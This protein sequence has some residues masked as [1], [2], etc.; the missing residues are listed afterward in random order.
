MARG[1]STVRSMRIIT[2]WKIGVGASLLSLSLSC[3]QT[4]MADELLPSIATERAG[5]EAS[6]VPFP[7]TPAK[8]GAWPARPLLDG[9]WEELTPEQAAGVVQRLRQYW[10][11]LRRGLS[12]DDW[13]L[14]QDA[15]RFRQL[16]LPFYMNVVLVEGEIRK[17]GQE[18]GLLTFLLHDRG[19]TLLTDSGGRGVIL[20]LNHWNPPQLDAPEYAAIYTKLFIGA[21]GGAKGDLRVLEDPNMVEWRTDE[22]RRA[23][24]ALEQ[25]I[26]PVLIRAEEKVW[27]T[28]TIIQSGETLVHAD[29]ALEHNG[30][31]RLLNGYTVGSALPIKR[32][33]YTRYLRHESF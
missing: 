15:T 28:E 23:H 26:R 13:P 7:S 8:T 19:V 16:P 29:F 4:A 5:P 21:M 31:L 24:G 27:V 30:W 22:D 3:L 9:K 6:G 10:R 11:E 1:T 33:H 18:P 17:A 25:V 14:L 2:L 32:T 20:D 12:E